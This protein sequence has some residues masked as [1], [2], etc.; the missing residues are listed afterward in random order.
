MLKLNAT[1]QPW[2]QNSTIEFFFILVP[3]ILPVLLLFVFKKYFFEHTQ[4]TSLWWVIL[5]LFIDVA[6]VY[7]TLFRMYWDKLT[8][9]KYKRHLWI[10]PL[11]GLIIGFCLHFSNAL[12]FWRM[13]AY[14]AVFHFIRQQ[15]GFMRLYS[16]KENNNQIYKVIDSLAIYSATLYPLI[17]WH[18]H[19]TNQLSWFV[20]GDFYSLS[21]PEPGNLLFYLYIGIAVLYF[22]KEVWGLIK[23]SQFNLPKNMVMLGTYLSWYVGIIVFRGDLAFTIL[24]V[25]AHGIPYMALVWIYGEKKSVTLKNFRFNLIGVLI[26]IGSVIILSYLEEGIWDIFIWKDHTD[27]FPFLIDFPAIENP[28]VLSIL[29]PILTLPQFTHYVLDGFI[30]RL[31]KNKV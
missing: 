7:S 9:Q 23:T 25:I 19:L 30:W 21:F 3:P 4:V 27:I 31:S 11:T 24:N 13:L 18:F 2:L 8:Y 28:I 22:T 16:R 20:E 1:R 17:Y 29:V 6:H 5:V 10:I 12:T 15:Y 26:F 14:L